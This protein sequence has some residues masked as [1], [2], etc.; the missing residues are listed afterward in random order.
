LW[1]SL[2][3]CC[4]ISHSFSPKLGYFPE[5]L[6]EGFI[7]ANETSQVTIPCSDLEGRE[8]KSSLLNIVLSHDED[9]LGGLRV[10]AK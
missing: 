9:T 7:L 5:P 4:Q 6:V 3:D 10:V 8:S 1:K 2:R